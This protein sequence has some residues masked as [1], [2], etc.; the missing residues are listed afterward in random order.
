MQANHTAGD[1]KTKRKPRVIRSK[2]QWQSLIS[3]YQRSSLTQQAFCEER[4]IT[5]SSFSKWRN[6]LA[7]PSDQELFVDLG[8]IPEADNAS[9]ACLGTS[10]W[11]VEL[12]LGKGIFL[13]VRTL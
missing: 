10:D 3:D 9:K 5:V 13:R 8:A 7:T 1:H 12:E 11:Q 6:Q 2:E 4:G